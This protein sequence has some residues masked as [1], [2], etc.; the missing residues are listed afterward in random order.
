MKLLNKL[1]NE[2]FVQSCSKGDYYRVQSF[3]DHYQIDIDYNNSQAM[4]LA[5]QNGYNDV[6]ELLYVY[7]SG[8]LNKSL[9]YSA[10]NGHEHIVRYLLENT[11]VDPNSF[12]SAAIF[13]AVNRN[14]TNTV[15]VLLENHSKIPDYC[16]YMAIF[17][18]N[19]K[20]IKLLMTFG[21]TIDETHI[22][23]AKK[24]KQTVCKFLQKELKK[25]NSKSIS[26]YIN[27][28]SFPTF[29]MYSTRLLNNQFVLMYTKDG[30]E[31][32]ILNINGTRM[33]L[34]VHNNN[35]YT[36]SMVK[37]YTQN[38][39]KKTYSDLRNTDLTLFPGLH[40]KSVNN[41]PAS[42]APLDFVIF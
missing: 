25:I 5:S 31:A 2:L 1:L 18:N 35:E 30:E 7:G 17:N 19:I 22:E 37:L 11:D 24:Q 32:Y 27:L 42:V 40:R 33:L 29:K 39:T 6:V 23:Y 9:Q 14:F 34:V 41:E 38:L 15:R 13:Y 12:N 10:Y 16:M 4:K 8:G 3:L 28:D 36:E 20:M 21:A 26:F